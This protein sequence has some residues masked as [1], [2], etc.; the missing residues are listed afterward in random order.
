M[1]WTRPS[2]RA[3][4]AEAIETRCEELQELVEREKRR[5]A[6]LQCPPYAQHRSS[7]V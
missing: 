3:A 6:K 4:D 2:R 5:N 7:F 1:T